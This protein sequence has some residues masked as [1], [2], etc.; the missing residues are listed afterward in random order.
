[1]YNVMYVVSSCDKTTC[2]N[3]FV[4]TGG[5]LQHFALTLQ[6]CTLKAAQLIE[7]CGSRTL[8]LFELCGSFNRIHTGCMCSVAL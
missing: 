8:K 2:S 5:K 7:L 4:Y 1:M 6:K 3:V